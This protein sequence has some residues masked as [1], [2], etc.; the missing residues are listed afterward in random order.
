MVEPPIQK[1]VSAPAFATTTYT[2]TV[3]DANGCID[4]DDVEVTVNPLP[5]ADAGADVAVCTGSSTTLGASGGTQYA[6]SPTTDL[7][8]PNIANP[9]C[10]PAAAR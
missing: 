8:N 9:V 1:S 3:T 10:T 7:S 4:T 6:W 5:P 2:L